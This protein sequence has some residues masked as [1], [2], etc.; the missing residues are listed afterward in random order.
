MKGLIRSFV[1]VMAVT[2]GSFALSGLAEAYERAGKDC[3]PGT[4]MGKGMGSEM[5]H[6]RWEKA[7]EKRMGRLSEVL[8]LTAEQKE[9][10]SKILSEGREELKGER[11]Q[12]MKR[13]ETRREATDKKIEGILNAEQKDKFR[14]HKEEMRKKWESRKDKMGHSPD[15]EGDAQ[16]KSGKSATPAE[17]AVP[18]RKK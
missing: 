10:L 5:R 8:S 2:L 7:H 6:D 15:E 14:A 17:P 16:E 4:G 3:G 11:E 9:K 12:M 18:S 1:F 13:A